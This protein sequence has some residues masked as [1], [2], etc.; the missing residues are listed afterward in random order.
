MTICIAGKNEIAI[1]TMLFIK[2]RYPNIN[3]IGIANAADKGV[4]AY[5]RSF[6]WFLNFSDIPEVAL[7]DIYEME[8]LVFISLEF[9]KLILPHKFLSKKLFNIHFSLLPAY[10]GMYTSAWPILNGEEFSG[11]SLHEINRGIDTG[12][13]IE[14]VKFKLD[15]SE[16]VQTLY[17]KYMEF[18]TT[19]IKKQLQSLIDNSYYKFPQPSI[20]STYYSKK[21]INYQNLSIKL[22]VTASQL[23]AQIRAFTYREYQILSVLGH[24]ISRSYITNKQSNLPAGKIISEDEESMK[25]STIDFDVI[26]YKDKFEEFINAC[27]RNDLKAVKR[28]FH[29]ANLEEKT[30]E[31]WTPLIVACY[32]N[33]FETAA[34]LLTQ[35]ADVDASNYKGTSVIMYA[36]NAVLNTGN[37]NIL[38][39]VLSYNPNIFNKDFHN[40]DI[41]EY[42]KDQSIGVAEYIKNYKHDKIS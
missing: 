18:G 29:H 7:D 41:F 19:L 27:E 36:K 9:D 13:I 23:D 5:F 38:K 6:K 10:K 21:S 37:F 8:N 4:N 12:D 25:I 35:G 40:K 28:L 11:V 24:K 20:G 16:T 14:Q 34:Y 30:N 2:E 3:V 26:L 31:G 33:S 32:N 22:N 42:L 17:K 39:L 1:N 15:L